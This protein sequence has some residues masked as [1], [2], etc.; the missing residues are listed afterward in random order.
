MSPPSP[1]GR[2]ARFA[3]L[4]LSLASVATACRMP[5]LDIPL[6]ARPLPQNSV[7]YAADGTRITTLHA[8]EDRV[9][10]P[11]ERI[12]K[13]VQ[14]AVIAVEDQR[15]WTHRGVDLRAMLRAAVVNASE[16]R[17]VEGGSTITQQYVKNAILGSERTLDR[18]VREATV[19]WRLE[20]TLSKA[21]ILER[22]LNTIYFGNGAYGVQS[23]ARRYFSKRGADLRLRE[24]ALLAGLIAG[25]ER[26]DPF[27]APAA[28]LQRRNLVLDRMLAQGM[29]APQAHAEAV[30]SPLGLEPPAPRERY[31][32]AHFVE[33]VK[34]RILSDERFGAT[35]ED[36]YNA[37]FKGGLRIHTTVDPRLQRAADEAVNGILSQ[38][39][40]P[41]GALTAID[42]RTGRI[43][44]MVGGRDFFAKRKR[45]PVARVNLATGDGG[46]GRQAGSSFKP[47]ALVAA[48][49]NG[50]SPKK[51][52]PGGSSIAIPMAHGSPWLVRNY[53][54]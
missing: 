49:E 15:F 50:M 51:R 46:T 11:L 1:F 27:E 48:L 7:I 29:I 43:V 6:E 25:P 13:V 2:A 30:A 54:G 53:E 4:V 12:P 9:I 33:F 31:P 23:A 34:K 5:N 42:P 17:I 24:A 37:L 41:H 10:L 8:E 26:Y 44:A 52:Y 16:G 20:R 35:R 21:E 3:V 22:Y 39:G 14:D 28:A 32:A 47:F 36:R 18:K 19:A 38:K 45:N 40:D